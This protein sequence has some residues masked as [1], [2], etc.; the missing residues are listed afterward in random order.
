MTHGTQ[1]MR[2]NMLL[3]ADGSRIL[4]P[5]PAY[6]TMRR[7]CR[8]NFLYTRDEV[9]KSVNMLKDCN[10]RF[11]RRNDKCIYMNR[12]FGTEISR[13]HGIIR[14]HVVARTAGNFLGSHPSI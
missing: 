14:G 3:G 9:F 2:L 13:H 7:D 8:N 6:R 4:T 12:I 11:T 5:L 1:R 10:D